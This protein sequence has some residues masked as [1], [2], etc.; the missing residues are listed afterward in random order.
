[1]NPERLKHEFPGKNIL[2]KEPTLKAEFSPHPDAN[3]ESR[4]KGLLR[5]QMNPQRDWGPKARAG[6]G[7]DSLETRRQKG[8]EKAKRKRELMVRKR[9]SEEQLFNYFNNFHS[10]T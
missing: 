5:W 3:P 10:F 8:I 1:V 9:L 2:A 7:A 4:Q 6:E